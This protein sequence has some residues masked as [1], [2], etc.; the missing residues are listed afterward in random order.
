[1]TG[2][3]VLE[4]AAGEDAVSLALS[5]GRTVEVDAVLVAAGRAANTAQLNLDAA[6]LEADERGR[7]K[8][9]EHYRTSRRA[10][11]RGGRRR[12]LSRPREHEH[13]ASAAGDG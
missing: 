5:S 4:C 3:R 2:E 7:I 8:V 6:G 10:H 9:N 12:G 11:L 1:M 13:G